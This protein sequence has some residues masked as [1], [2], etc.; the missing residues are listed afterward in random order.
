MN[1]ILFSDE[2]Y[3]VA[4]LRWESAAY[5]WGPVVNIFYTG[6]IFAWVFCDRDF[7]LKTDRSLF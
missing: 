7:F 2:V 4:G 1:K 3:T 6:S 5:F